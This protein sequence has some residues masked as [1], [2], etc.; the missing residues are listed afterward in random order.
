M[1]VGN[2]SGSFLRWQRWLDLLVLRPST[3][4]WDFK[5]GTHRAEGEERQGSFAKRVRIARGRS[6]RSSNVKYN[7]GSGS[8]LQGVLYL[9]HGA[10]STNLLVSF[11]S[12]VDMILGPEI[13]SIRVKPLTQE[14]RSLAAIQ[15]FIIRLEKRRPRSKKEPRLTRRIISLVH[16]SS[17]LAPSAAC[18]GKSSLL[19]P[20]PSNLV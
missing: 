10:H 17:T 6:L 1:R 12:G 16:Y 2:L 19:S 8:T 13:H 9:S 3:V 14:C 5:A 4:T 15:Y 20:S 7:A 18:Q 11:Y